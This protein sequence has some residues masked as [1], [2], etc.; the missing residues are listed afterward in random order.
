MKKLIV[1]GSTG[2]IGRHIVSQA[3]EA[4]HSVTAFARNPDK[5]EMAHDKLDKFEGDVMNPEAVVAAIAGHDIVL[6][7][8]GGGLKDT[9]RSEGT[10][11]II[12]AM[13]QCGVRRLICQTTLGAGDSVGNLNF[14]WKRIMFG[15]LIK[16]AF[17]DHQLQEK[18]IL[19]SE[20]DWT[21]VRPGAFTQ[22]P[23]TGQYQHGFSPNDRSVKL[24]ISRPDVA[25]FMLQ[26]IDDLSYL[27]QT[28]GLSY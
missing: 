11:N 18:Y 24:K 15:W 14:F 12:R 3:L 20:L 28:P 13:Q 17:Q 22:G 5:V 9:I 19:G 6:I 21:I 23:L 2:S 10:R 16:G 27:H 8:L 26:Q 4:G 1:F 7:A 25:H